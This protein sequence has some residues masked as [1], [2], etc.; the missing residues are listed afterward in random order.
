METCRKCGRQISEQM[1]FCPYCGEKKQDEAAQTPA[2]QNGESGGEFRQEEAKAGGGKPVFTLKRILIAAAVLLIVSM[3]G[4]V[5]SWKVKIS[6]ARSLYAQA[7]Y[8]NAYS[9]IRNVP[10]LGR[11]E[12]I[13]IKTAGDAGQY[14]SSYLTIKRIRLS[15]GASRSRDAYEDAF[16]DLT[17]GLYLNLRTLQRGG[18]DP[19]EADEY[20]KFV[21][22]MCDEL[23]ETFHMNRTQAEELA[24][25]FADMDSVQEMETASASWLAANFFK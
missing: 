8:W 23:R 25:S 13:R 11:E 22:I 14:Y 6:E 19:I 7:R 20:Q 5:I 9:T 21:N 17:F 16:W 12:L 24:L 2:E 18:L 15:P 3:A 1:K 4:M 10:T